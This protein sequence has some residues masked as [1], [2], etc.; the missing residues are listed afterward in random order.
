[1]FSDTKV[2]PVFEA[3]RSP[4]RFKFLLSKISFD[5]PRSRPEKLES[6]RFA[7]F[8]EF[9][10]KFNDNCSRYLTP[11]QFEFIDETLYPMSHQI[12]FC[13]YNPDKP[14]KYRLKFKSLH[15]TVVYAGKPQGDPNEFYNK[16]N[17]SCVKV[18]VNGALKHLFLQGRIAFTVA[19][20]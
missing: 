20:L 7:A 6:D 10:E 9:L 4:D 15:C 18:L 19:F 8:R 11:G 5:N 16:G 13:Q 12:A 17:F 2:F 3:A 1:M 14:A